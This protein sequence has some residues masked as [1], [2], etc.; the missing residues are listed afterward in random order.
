V[1]DAVDKKVR[2]VVD[3]TK[4]T[5]NKWKGEVRNTNYELSVNG[6][7]DRNVMK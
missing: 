6:K 7:S 2:G 3:G 1:R 5:L 4:Q